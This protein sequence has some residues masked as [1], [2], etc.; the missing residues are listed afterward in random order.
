MGGFFSSTISEFS[1]LTSGLPDFLNP[2]PPPGGITNM[3]APIAIKAAEGKQLLQTANKFSNKKNFFSGLSLFNRTR[4]FFGKSNSSHLASM[5]ALSAYGAAT[6]EKKKS[7]KT[8]EEQREN[9]IE[10]AKMLAKLPGI[11]KEEQKRKEAERKAK[12]LP[13]IK[14]KGEFVPM[15]GQF[16]KEIRIESVT[17]EN[18]IDTFINK[19]MSM[20][21]INNKYWNEK[22]K[23]T[24]D[25]MRQFKNVLISNIFTKQKI[26]TYE[27]LEKDKQY[28]EELK[29]ISYEKGNNEIKN[30]LQNNINE[31]TKK[32]AKIKEYLDEI[33]KLINTKKDDNDLLKKLKEKGINVEKKNLTPIH[34][35]IQQNIIKFLDK[36]NVKLV[37]LNKKIKQIEIN[38]ETAEERILK[39]IDP[40]IQSHRYILTNL[41]TIFDR[42]T[43]KDDI[44]K[45]IKMTVILSKI[46]SKNKEDYINIL[47]EAET[48]NSSRKKDDFV[49][50]LSQFESKLQEF[51]EK[52]PKT[53]KT[54][55]FEQLK[56][57]NNTKA[58]FEKE[59]KEFDM[60]KLQSTLNELLTELYKK[61]RIV[62]KNEDAPKISGKVPPRILHK[63]INYDALL[64]IITDLLN[65]LKAN[66]N[67]TN[68]KK[69]DRVKILKLKIIIDEFMSRM[70]SSNFEKIRYDM[71]SP[72]INS[73][74]ESSIGDFK[75]ESNKLKEDYKSKS[76]EQLKNEMNEL[77]KEIFSK[78]YPD[79]KNILQIGNISGNTQISPTEI[80]KNNNSASIGNT[81]IGNLNQS[82][83][84]NK[85][86][87]LLKKNQLPDQQLQAS[88]ILS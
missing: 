25:L 5:G 7:S 15:F 66:K 21:Y 34:I 12:E 33:N 65:K 74:L 46:N 83:I 84:N 69:K 76:I 18:F 88:L 14:P 53:N 55:V 86:L 24:R 82:K 42:V 30:E 63:S 78:Y 51:Y 62:I 41:S 45:L 52:L 40:I 27:K 43:E 20:D 80:K 29:E 37:E 87:K 26:N 71:N 50:R 68:N 44:D 72:Y 19:I 4:R 64:K 38:S 48:L 32:Q 49:L 1:K 85:E 47:Q 61:F 23:H 10:G 75:I 54:N 11:L 56:K 79:S 70:G 8:P 67:N 59:I 57:F 81:K 58:A 39:K 17:R 2:N 16:M 3:R 60:D 28:E 9:S 31:L 35:F 13:P 73:Y 6:A 22:E 77:L 36:I